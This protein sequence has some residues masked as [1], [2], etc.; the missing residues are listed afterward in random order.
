MSRL[1]TTGISLGTNPKAKRLSR[2]PSMDLR[3]R[4]TIEV[5]PPVP[6]PS[7][8]TKTKARSRSFVEPRQKTTSPTQPNFYIGERVAVDSMGVVGTLKF[9]GEAEFKE[10]LWAGIQLD[11][12]GS[13]K[14]D[15]SVKGIRYFDCPPQTGLFV[16]ASKLTPLDQQDSE[17]IRSLSPNK[18]SRAARYPPQLSGQKNR[19]SAPNIRT[20]TTNQV[21][22]LNTPATSPVSSSSNRHSIRSLPHIQSPTPTHYRGIP[23]PAVTPTNNASLQDDYDTILSSP[24]E[25][26]EMLTDTPIPLAVASESPQERLARVLGEAIDQAPDENVI[27]VQQLQLRVEV[28]EAENHYLKLENTQNKTAEKI[29]ER[30]LVLKGNG[31]ELFT[32]EGHKAIV[33]EIKQKHSEQEKD[34]EQKQQTT[35]QTIQRLETKIME[36]E[37]EQMNLI[38][39]RDRS[40]YDASAVRKEK[41]V[42]EHRLYE[43]E[44]KVVEAEAA[45]A[46]AQAGER[47]LLEKTKALQQQM[48]QATTSQQFFQPGL[49]SGDDRQIQLE[50]QM[51]EVHEK[52]SSLRDAARAKDMFLTSLSEQVEIHRNAVE[53]KEREIR[54][55]KADAE[56]HVR[57]KDRVLEEL[58][59]LEAKWLAHQDCASKETFDKLKKDYTTLKETY[60]A[61]SIRAQNYQDRIAGLQEMIDELKRAGME[62]IELYESSVEKHRMDR[63]ALEISLADERRKAS[64]LEAERDSLRKTG[65][66][67][68]EKFEATISE[69]KQERERLIEEQNAKREALEVTIAHLKQEIKQVMNNAATEELKDVWEK[70]RK[71]LTEQVVMSTEALEK[72]RLNHDQLRKEVE[73]WKEQVKKSEKLANERAQVE[74]QLA[75]LQT[76]YDEQLAARSKYLD[77]VRSAVESQKK[78]E[79]ELRRMTEQKEKLERDLQDKALSHVSGPIDLEKHQIEVETFRSEIEKLQAQNAMLMKQKEQAEMNQK[80]MTHYQQLIDSLKKEN[81]Q[82]TE[83]HTKLEESHKQTEA[84]C[85]KLMEEVEKLHQTEQQKPTVIQLEGL[86]NDDKVKEI[87]KHLQDTQKKLEQL[88]VNHMNELRKLKE[89]EES[90]EKEYKRHVA[91]LN[92]DISEL[93]SLIESKIFKEADM[94]E[95]LDKERKMVRKLQIEL[96]DLKDDLHVNKKEE[97]KSIAESLQEE[98]GPYC[99]ICE[100]YGHDLI[101][102]KAVSAQGDQPERPYCDNCEEYGFHSTE[103]CQNQNESF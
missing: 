71:R 77:E 24:P 88:N 99:E 41:S 14:N 33:E 28:L 83:K 74:E 1:P 3:K 82:L 90:E 66:E 96:Q 93:E 30:S 95:A 8:S 44:N 52:M 18:S 43:L 100:I 35:Q 49:D 37:T 101:S 78:A 53:E 63:E 46:A 92:R 60:Q 6:I 26:E 79:A 89:K 34:W 103:K 45:T 62:S 51:E 40:A 73:N 12:L 42:L 54:R 102:C 61:E 17:S 59:E 72:E 32:L 56:R 48:T 2:Q 76:D 68:I 21:T 23:S 38:T 67:T 65:Y 9:L 97:R 85:L 84:E 64:L 10:G 27:K 16:L 50:L 69:M 81:K 98:N 15:G 20:S 94:E 11:I 36:L 19:N 91:S 25:E 31:Q 57:E 4:K 29:L 13:G 22:S 80:G 70:E 55:I 87:S 39:E 58:K 86:G 5:P 47:L 75:R 7:K